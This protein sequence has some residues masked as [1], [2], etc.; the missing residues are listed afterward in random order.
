[1]I[2]FHQILVVMAMDPNN[3]M[4]QYVKHYLGKSRSESATTYSQHFGVI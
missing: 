3:K 4:C 2:F 1:M